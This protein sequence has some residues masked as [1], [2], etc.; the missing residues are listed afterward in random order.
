MILLRLI[1]TFALLLACG[2]ATFATNESIK[3]VVP[4]KVG[5]VLCG[6]VTDYGWNKAHNEGRLYLE[7]SMKG[8]VQTICAE[9]VS[10]N[11]DAVRVMEKM[12][13][14]G[15]KVIFGTA[16][17][18]YEPILQVAAHH[19]DVIFLQIG[20]YNEQQRPNVGI[21]FPYFF[22]PLYPAGIV[23]GRQTASNSIGY[24]VGHAVPGVLVGVNA[25]TLGAKSVNPKVTVHLV[26]TN[27]WNNPSTEAEATKA[28]AENGSDIV[29][30]NL[31]S[32]LTVSRCAEKAKIYSVGIHED[33][34][35]QV[36]Q[37]WLT[38]LS[39]N[40][41]PL[42]KRILLEVI[43]DNWKPGTEYYK[44]KDGYVTLT[45]FGNMVSDKTKSQAN[46]IFQKI[47]DGKLDIFTGPMKDNRGNL[48]ILPGKTADNHCIEHMN[49]VVPGV[50]G[51]SGK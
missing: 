12:I 18:F 9:N 30:S 26:C 38:G 43:S 3:Q 25:F 42:Y 19:P 6:Y 24:I 17:G 14:Q 33:L 11:A 29:V 45:S 31:D 2:N 34:N 22:E 32:S 23:A 15:T 5:F 40:F 10:E 16:Y 21:Y 27:S 8:K 47:K 51:Y 36:P 39:W 35:K 49:W 1:L 50:E 7:E 4:I 13:A 28:L 37:A 46:L 20:R 48:K 41:G 44:A